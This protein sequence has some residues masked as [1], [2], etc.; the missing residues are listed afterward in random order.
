[1]V[2][3]ISEFDVWRPGYGGA[4]VAVYIAGT[5]TLASIYTDEALSVAADNPITLSSMAAPDGTRYG[6]FAAPLYINQ[7]YYLSIDGIENTGIIRPGIISLDGEDAKS[8]TVIAQGASYAVTLAALAGREVNVANFGVFTEGAGGVAA[9]NTAT[10]E[11]AIAALSDGGYV[12]VPAGLYKVNTFDVPAGVIIR[13]QGVDATTLQSITGAASFTIVGDGAG[14]SDIT[15]DGSSLTSGSIAVKSEGNDAVVFD[16]VKI[17]AFETGIYLYGGASFVWNDFSIDNTG[18]AAKLFGE[19]AV[20]EDLIWNGGVI[21]VAATLGV[22]MSY[23]DQICQN[24]TFIGVVFNSCVGYAVNINGAQNIKF[25]G[26][27]WDTNTLTVNIQDDTAVLT[28]STEQ[29]NDV[30]TVLFDGGRMDG[31]EFEA[32]GTCQNVMLKNMRLTDIELIMSTPID[33]FIVLENCYE[34]SDVVI[35]GETGKLIR[36]T[37]SQNGASFGLTTAAAATKAWSIPL[38]PGQQ[39]YLEGKVIAKGRNVVQRAIYH[40]GCGAYRP[41]STL[42][43]D[44]QTANF[45]AGTIV[46]GASSGATARIQ[47]DSDSGTTGTLTLVDIQGEFI[48]NEII[49]DSNG[50]PGS[51][52]VNGTLNSQNATLDST[53][54]V[55]LRAVFE[56]TAGFAAAFVANGTEIELQ[57]TGATSNTLEWTVHVD[58]VST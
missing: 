26:C 6:K 20:F 41:G 5:S 46:T 49:T 38:A 51:A 10:M 33:N 19:D 48:D 22:N 56:S 32:T 29:N 57:V 27:S 34:D 17:E 16:R 28:P 14:F 58:V 30:I 24:I 45:T 3:R 15:L 8:A 21:S 42:N 53:G 9:T 47:A 52:T 12:N 54:N 1:M 23:E 36:A 35:S 7:S 50:T 44:T 31:G 11:L 4:S 43:Y 39:V 18:T 37:T 40:I 25:Y 13:G 55:N 2:Q